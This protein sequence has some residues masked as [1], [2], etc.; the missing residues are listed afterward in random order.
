MC[1]RDRWKW[2]HTALRKISLKPVISSSKFICPLLSKGK[3]SCCSLYCSTTEV[4]EL[5]FR[6]L[7]FF[8]ENKITKSKY[9]NKFIDGH[10]DNY[11]QMMTTIHPIKKKLLMKVSAILLITNK[12][13]S[14]THLDVYKRQ[15]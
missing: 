4:V 6:V 9:R 15:L 3:M 13:V 7:G 14:Y 2:S 12:P 11:I 8:L 10:L 1:I 5:Y